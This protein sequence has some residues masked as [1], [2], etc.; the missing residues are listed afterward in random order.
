[1]R[2]AFPQVL[3]FHTFLM[4]EHHYNENQNNHLGMPREHKRT[5]QL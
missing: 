4:K 5:P 3:I 2:P 1:L